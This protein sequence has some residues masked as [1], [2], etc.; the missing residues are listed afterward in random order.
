LA[1]WGTVTQKCF[2]SDFSCT[3]LGPGEESDFNIV[4]ESSNFN[5]ASGFDVTPP[6]FADVYPD[7]D[8]AT[9][10][11]NSVDLLVQTNEYVNIYVAISVEDAVYYEP[12]EAG[13][14]VNWAVGPEDPSVPPIRSWSGYTGILSADNTHVKTNSC[15]VVPV[16]L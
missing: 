3:F 15:P 1:F 13:E 9:L 6:V 12:S 11:A 2:L 5:L 14:V 16:M 4:A 8:P 7:Y 10:T